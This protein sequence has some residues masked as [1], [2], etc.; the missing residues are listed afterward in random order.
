[1]TWL[2]WSSLVLA[3]VGLLTSLVAGGMLHREHFTLPFHVLAVVGIMVLYLLASPIFILANII[4]RRR[5]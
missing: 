4:V 1:M 2:D 3:I 5:R